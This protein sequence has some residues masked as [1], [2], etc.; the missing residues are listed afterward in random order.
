MSA[1]PVSSSV[2]TLMP[3]SIENV[4]RFRKG[5]AGAGGPAASRGG[6]G[7]V[8]RGAGSENESSINFGKQGNRI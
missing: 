3:S 2:G 6:V 4:R 5:C 8:S 1:P 7:S